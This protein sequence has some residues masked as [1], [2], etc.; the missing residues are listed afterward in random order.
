MKTI[1]KPYRLP[2]ILVT[3]LFL[4]W[5]L[6]NNMTDTLLAAF[7]RIMD[8]S[9]AQ[10]SLIQFAFYGSYFCF[11]LPAALYIRKRSYKSGIILGLLLYASGAILFYPAARVASYAFY[12]IA[13]YIMAG[14]CSILETTANPY[15]LSMGT[16]ESAT[17]RL[18][19]AQ[20]FNP[21][22]SIMGILLS[23]YFILD[24]ISLHSVSATYA[25]LGAVLLLIL[26]VM[27]CIPMPL[28]KDAVAQ[29]PLGATFKRLIAEKRYLGGVIAQFFYVGAQIGVWSFTIRIVMEELAVMEAQASNIYL[30][31]IIGFCLSRFVYSGLMKWVA[32]ARLLVAGGCLSAIMAMVVVMSAGTGWV[33]VSALML[34]SIFMSLMFPTIYGLALGVSPRVHILKTLRL[35]PAD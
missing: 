35:A 1:E 12:L 33:M 22:G 32:P 27:L 14:G 18:N 31:S 25:S 16:P 20:S 34:I 3:S 8:M 30:L 17:R 7:K 24:S 5:G 26:L 13:I 11:A 21:I 28:G 29:N 2:F 6:A 4:L 23:K 10:T 15:I 19:I 9:D